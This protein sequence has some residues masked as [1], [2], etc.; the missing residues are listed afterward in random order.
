MVVGEETLVAS[1]EDGIQEKS[2]GLE[3]LLHVVAFDK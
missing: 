1:T 3:Y 2:L